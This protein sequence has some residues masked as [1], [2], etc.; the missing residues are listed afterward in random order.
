LFCPEKSHGASGVPEAFHP[1][2]HHANDPEEIEKLVKIQ[3]SHME[4][5]ARFL[6]KLATFR[7]ARLTG[8]TTYFSRTREIFVALICVQICD[9]HRDQR[10]IVQRLFSPLLISTDVEVLRF[11]VFHP[12]RI[13]RLSFCFPTIA[14]HFFHVF[15]PY[16]PELGKKTPFSRKARP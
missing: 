2:S 8:T 3:T 5:F 12:L 16:N 6:G 1:L 11:C 13:T 4:S 10:S 9:T 14:H 15:L 7:F